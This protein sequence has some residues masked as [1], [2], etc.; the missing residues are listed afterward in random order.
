MEDYA[1]LRRDFCFRTVRWMN[2]FFRHGE[3]AS[4]FG[5]VPV[6][7]GRVGGGW[8][9]RFGDTQNPNTDDAYRRYVGQFMRFL[10]NER[11]AQFREVVRVRVMARRKILLSGKL[12]PATIRQKLSAVS[13]SFEY[14]CGRDSIANNPAIGITR[15]SEGANE[16]KTPAL[17]NDQARVLLEAPPI[18]T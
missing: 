15:P 13:S 6:T 4:G 16:G 14:L 8:V 5:G 18:E 3:S 12:S 10:G 9:V 17:S 7:G 2:W 1:W 11:P